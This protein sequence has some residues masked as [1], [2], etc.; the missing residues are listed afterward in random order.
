M[1]R[2]RNGLLVEIGDLAKKACR[3]RLRGFRIQRH[4]GGDRQS[5]PSVE[6]P[7]PWSLNWARR[8]SS[9]FNLSPRMPLQNAKSLETFREKASVVR[10]QR[11]G[12]PRFPKRFAQCS[13][14]S[15]RGSSKVL[16]LPTALRDPP[17]KTSKGFGRHSALRWSLTERFAAPSGNNAFE[18]QT[19]TAHF[20]L[21][22]QDLPR[23]AA[24]GKGRR[25]C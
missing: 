6:L 23:R 15:E 17:S 11:P 20:F 4:G 1:R 18:N 9:R 12:H 13:F 19:I 14:C 2:F 16:L 8:S 21:G 10:S 22:R 24:R 5:A 7:S 25:F 3:A